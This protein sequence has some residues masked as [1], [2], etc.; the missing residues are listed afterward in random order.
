[1]IARIVEEIADGYDAEY[2]GFGHEPKF[3][4]PDALE[5]LL[6]EYRRSV[7]LGTPDQRLYM[8][9]AKTALGMSRGG[10]YDH[11]E[12][13]FF[14]YSTTRDWS[15]PHFEKMSEDHGGLLRVF[16][17]LYRVSHNNDFR[18]T[19]RSASLYVRTTLRDPQTGRFYGSQDADEEYFAL[20]LDERRKRTAPYIDRTS[21]TNWSANL[22]SAFFAAADVLDDDDL[23][24]DALCALD[25]I[26]ETMVDE[27]GLAYHYIVPGGEP[28][29]RGLLTDQVA[30]LRALIDAHEWSGEL[31]FVERA[32]LLADAV[33]KRFRDDRGAYTDHASVEEV[34]GRVRLA[35]APLNDNGHAA[36]ALLRLAI[37]ADDP[38]Y[39]E[40]A[41]RIL[42]V[43][44]KSYGKSGSFAASYVAA[45]RRALDPVVSV[46]IS[47]GP[48][49]TELFRE[50][51]RALP[52]PL[53][54]IRSTGGTGDPQAYVCEGTTC[55]AP[56]RTPAELTP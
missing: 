30:Y 24:N 7:A 41:R 56:V 43:F 51:A 18:E 12:G 9:L 23:A 13:G 6:L 47:G 35:S 5:L 8:M 21:Y 1:M 53:V 27:D 52:N 55:R 39:A 38:R 48:A 44:V 31:R 4:Q 29:V 22:A 14:R 50:A 25:G 36:D 26:A 3:P 20:P 54:T 11:A 2:G 16:S 19:L 46:T 17:G 49:Q 32:R 42:S 15:V 40:V 37:V 10:M 33:E 45:V 28:S 34:L